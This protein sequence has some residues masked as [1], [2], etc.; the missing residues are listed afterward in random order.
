V[1]GNLN[2]VTLRDHG[3]YETS[4]APEGLGVAL[5][6]MG[7]MLTR[8]LLSHLDIE[9]AIII[10]EMLDEV[11]EKGRD[12]DLD[13][14][15]KIALFGRHPLS[16][17]IAGTPETVRSFTD[18][19]VREHLRRHYVSG[20]MV[21]CAA[22]RVER[23]AVLDH[24]G[25]AF[26]ALPRGLANSEAPPVFTR[27]EPRLD[28][29]EHDEAQTEF[30]LT[31]PT[32]PETHP[33]FSALQLVRRVLDDGLSSR[34]P[35]EVVEKRG[36]AYSLNCSLEMYSDVGLLEVDGACAPERAAEVV[37]ACLEVLGKLCA[38]GPTEAELVRARRRHRMFLDFAQDS[39]GEL[40]G[41]FG[42][43]EL[44]R[45]PE[46]FEERAASVDA[47]SLAE[48]QAVARRYLTRDNL[49]AVAVGPRKGL[50]ELERAVALASALPPR[51]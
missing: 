24:V 16:M 40:A 25:R 35:Y 41:W 19:Q 6:I 27:G 32:I 50:K 42:G 39:P 13:N 49:L 22:G 4:I 1:G 8:P 12:V 34:L 3:F 45:P 11:D 28:F 46:S 31:F 43:T 26:G 14:L 48:V 30:R 23:A 7:D 10:E 20:N 51:G 15:S 17:K 44:F 29:T 9:R 37:T 18:A 36:L 38:D 2:G 5:E 33:D 47:T 21:V